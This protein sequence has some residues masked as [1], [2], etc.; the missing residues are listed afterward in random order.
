MQRLMGRLRRHRYLVILLLSGLLVP[1]TTN[2][3][4]SWLETTL[5]QTSNR[6]LQLLALGVA[7]VVGLWVL[8]L[9]LDREE[10]VELVPEEER[11]PRYPGLIVLVGTGRKG[12]GPEELSHQPAIEYHLE[13]EEAGSEPL[14]VCWLIATG[15]LMGSVPVA[16]QV[17]SRYSD[18]CQMHLRVLADAFD[19]EEA[20]HLAHRI[21]TQEATECGL[22]PDQIIADFT[23][24]TKPMSAGVILACQ[25]RWPMQYMFG[26]K[27]EVASTPI[28]VRF[29]G[30]QRSVE[31]GDR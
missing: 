18:R 19:V 13:R 3:G 11:P 16:R 6:L 21:Y 17:R 1:L 4:S 24:G 23:G 30:R 25:D 10:P 22:T 15:G 9:A 12:A 27:G 2:L 26:R 8:N 14:R 5:G 28:L 31:V 20:Y 7:L 29:R